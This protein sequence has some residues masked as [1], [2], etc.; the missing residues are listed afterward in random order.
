LTTI[1]S[2]PTA[3]HVS[4]SAP[5]GPNELGLTALPGSS[6][7]FAPIVISIDPNQPVQDA[8]ATVVHE[9]AH[10][11][12]SSEFQAR[13]TEIQFY[14]QLSKSLGYDLMYPDYKVT[15]PGGSGPVV[16]YDP[17]KKQYNI[18]TSNLKVYL[19]NLKYKAPMSAPTLPKETPPLK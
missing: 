6:A 17:N 11:K 15:P 9:V 12:G 4:L 14:N 2:N 1:R 13:I 8:A 10:A 16:V 5:S 18:S 19:K 7:P 3:L